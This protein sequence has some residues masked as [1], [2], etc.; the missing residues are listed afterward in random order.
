M[1]K[2]MMMMM[3][4]IILIKAHMKIRRVGDESYRLNLRTD[5]T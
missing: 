5:S 1:M 4:M 2:K 3:M